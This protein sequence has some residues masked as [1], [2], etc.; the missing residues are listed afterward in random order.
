MLEHLRQRVVQTLANVHTAT[1][2]T[3][4]PAGLRAS[5]LPCE[6]SGIEL[7]VLVP[8]AS[9]HL[10]NLES[11]PDVVVVNE[12]WNLQ[13]VARV[14]PKPDASLELGLTRSPEMGWS[15]V[16]W[17]HPRRLTL[18]RT[19]AGSPAETIDVA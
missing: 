4:G 18:L 7:Y 17:I 10:F 15:E 16:V 3:F 13:G 19:S 2:S 11:E 8:R 9:D 12:V 1:L 5:R 6:A 14:I